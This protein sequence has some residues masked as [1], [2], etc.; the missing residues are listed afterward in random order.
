MSLRPS[1]AICIPA[2]NAAEYLPKLFSS[3]EKQ[4]PSFDE[5]LLYND[6]STDNTVEIVK[7][8]DVKVV[9]GKVN[10][11]CSFGKNELAKETFCDWIHFHDADDDILDN[12]TTKIYEWIEKYGDVFDVLLLNFNYVDFETKKILGKANHNIQELHSD[13]LRY[14]IANKIV[15]FG[16]YKKSSFIAAGGFDTD[17]K[18]L[19]NEDNAFHQRLAKQGLKFDYLETVTCI[20]YRYD[21]SMSSSNVLKCARANYYV[22][23]HTAK[24]YGA[25][26]P[27]ELNLQLWN[28]IAILGSHKDWTYVKKCLAIIKSLPIKK[29]RYTS[30]FEIFKSFSPLSAV[31]FRE[32]MI[33]AFKS[34]L[35]KIK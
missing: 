19:Y 21:K 8:L 16:I 14:S 6:C 34:H 35:R 27:D 3:I 31:K 11:G 5:V 22:L 23:A 12:F 24:E 26:Y 13:P 25:K 33:R 9:N 2:Y 15:N 30:L 7:K 32:Y 18:V 17:P 28:C 4:I 29:P 1:L 20:N 10:K